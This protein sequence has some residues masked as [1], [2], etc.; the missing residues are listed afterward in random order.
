MGTRAVERG[1]VAEGVASRAKS[2]R[3]EL[4]LSQ[5]G[6]ADRLAA[7]GRPMQPSAVSKV[8]AGDRRVD[9]D[10]LV[11]LAAALETTTSYLLTGER[12]PDPSDVT[13]D[14]LVEN[15][16][17]LGAVMSAAMDALD[18][19]VPHDVLLAQMTYFLPF[20]RSMRE[21]VAKRTKED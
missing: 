13:L 11:A 14:E 2:R 9:V 12:V 8:E 17:R 19:G 10:D 4:G 16:D 6:L 20:M 1:P 3:E 18:D 7:E 15:E 21:T 5:R